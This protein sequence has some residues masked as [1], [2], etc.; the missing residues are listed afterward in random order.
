MNIRVKILSILIICKFF[1]F[2]YAFAEEKNTFVVS[3]LCQYKW[4]FEQCLAANKDGSTRTIEDFVCLASSN[5]FEIMAQIILDKEFKKIDKEVDTYFKNL[6]DN[7]SYYFGKDSKEPFTNAI[8]V[9]E[10]K[11]DIY[12]E[13]G[14]KYLWVCGATS[15]A[16]VLQQTIN[17]FGW[18]IPADESTKYF[19]SDTSCK[20]LILTKLEVNKQVAYDVLKLN[21]HQIKKDEDKTHMQRERNKYDKLLEIIMVNVGYLERIWKKWPS[22]TKSASGS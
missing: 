19:L 20:N 16:W 21:K 1:F 18:S 17:C 14:M 7:K 22:K 9:I 3:D 6:E 13:F 12:G 5:Y 10:D 4:P 2:F 11:F 8:D 15:E